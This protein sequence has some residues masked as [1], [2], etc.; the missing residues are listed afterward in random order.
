LFASDTLLLGRVTYDGFVA[1]WPLRSG[2][3]FTDKMNSIKKVVASR[4][5][6]LPLAWNATLLEGDVVRAVRTLKEQPGDDILICGSGTLVRSLMPN[7]LIDQYRF[8]VYPMILGCGKRLFSDGLQRV[9]LRL[10]RATT[11]QKG[12]TLLPMNARPDWR[13]CDPAVL[14]RRLR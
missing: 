3:A 8:I 10:V 6:S 13:G 12:V 4:N 1:A 7:G 11:T 5:A 14:S 2:D 9:D